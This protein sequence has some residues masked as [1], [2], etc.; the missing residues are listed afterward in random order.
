MTGKSEPRQ[1]PRAPIELKVEYQRLNRF[2]F[3][4]AKNISRG[5]TFIRTDK[6]LPVGT[7]FLF[8]LFVPHLP[9]PL[10]F[11]GEVR[12][13]KLPDGE[14][15]AGGAGSRTGTGG[16]LEKGWQERS[17]EA[18]GG[19][20][21]EGSGG[22]AE[23]H[24]REDS[25]VRSQEGPQED[26]QDGPGMGIGFVYQNDEERRV[27]ERMVERLMIESLGQRIF[28]HLRGRAGGT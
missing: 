20:P 6:P 15:P 14:R 13:V 27:V 11:N 23:V 16:D 9:D 7:L 22:D 10:V 25:E 5:G 12:W 17:E 21:G 1:E 2:F 19:R 3:D 24:S 18:P 28:A 26:L 4:Y 8:K